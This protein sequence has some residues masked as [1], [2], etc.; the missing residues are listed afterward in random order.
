VLEK[1]DDEK[2]KK[3]KKN[4]WKIQ[5]SQTLLKDQT[6]EILCPIMIKSF[7][8]TGNIRNVPQYNAICMTNQHHIKW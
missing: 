3:I 8:E 2:G 4:E 6:Y 7:E 1:S 5:E